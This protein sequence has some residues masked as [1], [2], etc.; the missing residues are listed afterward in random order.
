[1][2]KIKAIE[3]KVVVEVMKKDER[4]V[5]GLYIPDTAEKEPQTYGTVISVGDK[6]TTIKEGDVIL[7]AKHGG[8][9]FIVDGKTYKCYMLPEIYSILYDDGK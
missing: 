6:V 9:A 4:T 5:S 7:A 1:M 3:D 2:K 8:Q